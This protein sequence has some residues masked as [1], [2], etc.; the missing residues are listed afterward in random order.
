[1]TVGKSLVAIYDWTFLLGRRNVWELSLDIY[2][3]VKG[4]RPSP[5]TAG[6]TAGT[7]TPSAAREFAS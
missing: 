5:I 2:L 4:F 3:M 6:M 1:M 7:A